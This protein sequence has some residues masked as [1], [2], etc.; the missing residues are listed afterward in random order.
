MIIRVSR[1]ENSLYC[2]ALDSEILAIFDVLASRIGI[3][4]MDRGRR[5]IESS[6]V[7]D[8]T[9]VVMVEMRNERAADNCV[10]GGE[11]LLEPVKPYRDAL[12]CVDE[13]A[14]AAG[15]EKIGV[16]ALELK[17]FT[18]AKLRCC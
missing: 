9:D 2:R 8:T 13:E 6:Q 14:F 3:A 15:T 10:F 5:G 12:S 17:L 16:C 11:N 1:R 7:C 18:A 4:F